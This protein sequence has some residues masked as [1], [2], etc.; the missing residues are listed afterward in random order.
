[1]VRFEAAD[2]RLFTNVWICMS[3]N[4]KN[5]C[6]PGKKPRHCRKCKGNRLRLKHKTK[7][8]KGSK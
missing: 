5:R 4:A 8:A 2:N 6:S 1:M 7:K 3:C